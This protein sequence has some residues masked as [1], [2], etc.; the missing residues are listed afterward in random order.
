MAWTTLP[1]HLQGIQRLTEEIVVKWTNDNLPHPHVET[2]DSLMSVLSV[3]FG[4][5]EEEAWLQVKCSTLEGPGVLWNVIQD[6][7]LRSC[8]SLSTKILVIGIKHGL[9]GGQFVP[10]VF[11]QCVRNTLESG[12][13]NWH[14]DNLSQCRSLFS[15]SHG[16]SHYRPYIGHPSCWWGEEGHSQVSHCCV[17]FDHKVAVSSWP[18]RQFCH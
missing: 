5:T 2:T 16:G 9:K 8:W 7:I 10:V 14:L 12:A 11:V 13:C 1:L 3:A 15:W 17:H 6:Y 4:V 18:A